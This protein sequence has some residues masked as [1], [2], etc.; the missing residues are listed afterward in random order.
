MQLVLGHAGVSNISNMTVVHA[1][2]LTLRM[3]S[4]CSSHTMSTAFSSQSKISLYQVTVSNRLVSSPCCIVT[5]TYGWTANMER[6]MKAQALRDNS[7]MGYMMAKKHLEI[8]PDHPIVETLRQKAEADK[9][10]KAVKDLVIL[11]FE[12]A[13]LSSGF[14]LDD[15]QTHSNRI[16]RMIK[17]GLGEKT[18]HFP[19]IFFFFFPS[20]NSRIGTEI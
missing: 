19:A 17:L 15:P 1:F 20:C 16:Y 12:T 3:G 5:S 11:L 10:D 8:N 4:A 7:T 6:I 2:N 14:S 13:L 18:A 9:N